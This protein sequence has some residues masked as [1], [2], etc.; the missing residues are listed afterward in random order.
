MKPPPALAPRTGVSIEWPILNLR[1]AYFGQYRS[2]GTVRIQP[3]VS[4]IEFVS[5]LI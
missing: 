2:V 3:S 5:V 4:Q 1:V